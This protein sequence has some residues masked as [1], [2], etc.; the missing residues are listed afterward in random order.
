MKSFE[1]SIRETHFELPVPSKGHK[2][3]FEQRL[4]LYFGASKRLNW[5]LPA[6]AASIILLVSVFSI[7]VL[8]KEPTKSTLVLP[9]ENSEY[10]ESEVYFQNMIDQKLARL[11]KYDSKIVS[12]ISEIQ[13][14][15]ESLQMLK[16]D[17]LEAPGDQR[18]VEAVLH[19]YMLKIEALDN[20]VNILSKTS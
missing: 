9:I 20:L 3:R 12:H 5:Y 7:T 8:R 17:L 4:D 10:Y 15:D 19:T 1:K 13:E 18:I 2:K 14:F 6:Y 11:K 16:N